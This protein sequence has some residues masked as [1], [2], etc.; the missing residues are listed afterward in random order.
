MPNHHTLHGKN[1]KQKNKALYLLWFSSDTFPGAGTVRAPGVCRGP[2]RNLPQGQ[3]CCQQS[4]QKA[5][6][7]CSGHRLSLMEQLCVYANPMTSV[8]DYL[9]LASLCC[10]EASTNIPVL[11]FQALQI[12]TA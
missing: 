8:G 7:V 10:Q 1:T 9:L 2:G 12:C 3:I 4:S 5:Q 11:L 6:R